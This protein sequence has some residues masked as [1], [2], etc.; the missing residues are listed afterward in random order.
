MYREEFIKAL[1]KGIGYDFMAN[2]Y[3][4]FSKSE[5]KDIVLELLYELE[6]AHGCDRVPDIDNVIPEL[7]D[8]WDLTEETAEPIAPFK[9]ENMFLE[10]D[11]Q[12]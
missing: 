12:E 5:L 3:P 9:G 8:R 10:T 11:W 7:E 6:V 2:H 4:N 1:E